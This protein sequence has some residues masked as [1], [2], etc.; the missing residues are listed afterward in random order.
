VAAAVA[1]RAAAGPPSPDRQVA[2]FQPETAEPTA[3]TCPEY[4]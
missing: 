2:L 3:A 1:A 4:S